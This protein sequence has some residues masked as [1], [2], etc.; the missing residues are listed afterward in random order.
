ML[1]GCVP[2]PEQ[3]KEKYIRNGYWEQTPIGKAFD[4]IAE[5]FPDRE[6]L[7]LE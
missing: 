3:F 6:A 1:E 2:W 4:R 5:F 7:V